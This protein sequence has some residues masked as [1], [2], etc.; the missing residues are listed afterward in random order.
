[1]L[2]TPTLNQGLVRVLDQQAGASLQD[3]D[4][5]TDAVIAAINASGEAFFSG[6]S[7]R[8]GGSA[9]NPLVIAS[10]AGSSESQKTQRS[11]D[12]DT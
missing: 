2:W 12:Q 8:G 10:S 9:G 6:T 4:R 3:H 7:W 5:R 11:R 1:M